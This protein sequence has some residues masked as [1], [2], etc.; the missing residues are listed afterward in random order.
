MR[1]NESLLGQHPKTPRVF[2]VAERR[3]LRRQTPKTAQRRG[4]QRPH[5]RDTR[6]RQWNFVDRPL[7]SPLCGGFIP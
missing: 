4:R 1:V 5:S 3:I 6:L 2:K 7:L